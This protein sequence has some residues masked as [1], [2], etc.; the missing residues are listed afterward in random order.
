MKNWH[1]LLS[2]EVFFSL[3]TIFF[4]LGRGGGMDELRKLLIPMLHKIIFGVNPRMDR[5]AFNWFQSW[6]H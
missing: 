5:W 1:Y 2:K 6:A 4:P 3:E